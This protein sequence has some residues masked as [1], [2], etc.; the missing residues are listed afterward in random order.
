MG[1]NSGWDIPPGCVVII[2]FIVFGLVCGMGPFA[3]FFGGG[4]LGGW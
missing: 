2:M 4:L 3:A 1:E